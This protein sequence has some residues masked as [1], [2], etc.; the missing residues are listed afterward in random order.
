MHHA[1]IDS[2]ASQ[3]GPLQR[4][5]ARVKL[6]VTLGYVVAV[7]LTVPGPSLAVY[8]FL[9]VVTAAFARVPLLFLGRRL[10]VLLP[11]TLL[12]ALFIPFTAGGAL[13]MGLGAP[14]REG[15]L[16]AGVVVARALCSAGALL[17]LAATTPMHELLAALR[18][19]RVPSIL[20]VV[21]GLLY[22]YLFVL[23]DET[24]R[25][26]RA[27]AQRGGSGL[28]GV[29]GGAALLGTL[30]MRA[31]DR[32]LAVHRAMLARGL[33]NEPKREKARPLSRTDIA[34]LTVAA[35]L[36]GGALMLGFVS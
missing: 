17:L 21:L 30:L 19:I 31:T 14:T 22:R 10:L 24:E 27:R 32:A 8:A 35:G 15:F 2:L 18:W 29:R 3:E 9:L 12:P 1:Q 36:I 26:A 6:L 34:F 16:A 28:G 5:D 4:R 25:M 23:V 20:V 33:G 13:G 7:S 11:F